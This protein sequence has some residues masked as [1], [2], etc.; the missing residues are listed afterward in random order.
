MGW[1]YL[2]ESLVRERAHLHYGHNDTHTV[3]RDLGNIG[4][5]LNARDCVH[6]IYTALSSFHTLSLPYSEKRWYAYAKNILRLLFT[7]TIRP[8]PAYPTSSTARDSTFC[9]PAFFTHARYSTSVSTGRVV[10]LCG[11]R[12]LLARTHSSAHVRHGRWI[13]GNI[14]DDDNHDSNTLD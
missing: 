4:L 6:T 5:P 14:L 3:K 11:E 9:W 10:G 13:R 7:L 2:N 8:S 12:R 1:I